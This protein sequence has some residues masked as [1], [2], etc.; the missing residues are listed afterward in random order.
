M[1]AIEHK[2]NPLL[3]EVFYTGQRVVIPVC[4]I[5]FNVGS[6]TIWIHSPQGGTAVRLK[7]TGKINTNQCKNSPISHSDIMIDGAI[8]FCLSK[9]AVSR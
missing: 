3:Q 6:H 4:A 1:P 9:D 2:T 7:C 8:E 5:E